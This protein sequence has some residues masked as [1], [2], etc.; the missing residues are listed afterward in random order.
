MDAGRTEASAGERAPVAGSV[1]EVLGNR[2]V[3]AVPG[4]RVS[5]LAGPSPLPQQVLPRGPPG[6]LVPVTGSKVSPLAAPSPQSPQVPLPVPPQGR[7]GPLVPVPVPGEWGSPAVAQRSRRASCSNGTQ[8]APLGSV[9]DCRALGP[10]FETCCPVGRCNN[11]S[12]RGSWAPF[13]PVGPSRLLRGLFIKA[14]RLCLQNCS[15]PSD[16]GPSLGPGPLTLPQETASVPHRLGG[17]Q[18]GHDLAHCPTEEVDA[19]DGRDAHEEHPQLPNGIDA[20][21]GVD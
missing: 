4:S 1:L 18:V 15:L 19:V 9:E 8:A 11:G 7:H 12:Q 21:L 6:P 20:G 16:A 13:S 2:R 10:V 3:V 5:Q 17:Q 14:F